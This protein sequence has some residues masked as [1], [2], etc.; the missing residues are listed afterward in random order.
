MLNSPDRFRVVVTFTEVGWKVVMPHYFSN[1][2]C[3][4]KS[5]F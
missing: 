2:W 3:G 4:G 5:S 1:F